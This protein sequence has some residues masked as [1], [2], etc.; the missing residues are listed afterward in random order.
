MG[1]D[2]FNDELWKEARKTIYAARG[3]VDQEVKKAKKAWPYA[4]AGGIV[5]LVIVLII[6]AL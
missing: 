6:W 1:N 3:E 5:V 2:E 4:L